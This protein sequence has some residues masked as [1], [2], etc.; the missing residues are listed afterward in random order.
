MTH[1][2][3]AAPVVVSCRSDISGNVYQLSDTPSP[4]TRIVLNATVSAQSHVTIDATGKLLFPG[5]PIKEVWCAT[6]GGDAVGITTAIDNQ[7]VDVTFSSQY[8]GT[9]LCRID[10]SEYTRRYQ[11][12]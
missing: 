11:V 9:V 3:G 1:S 2:P 10:Q 12:V 8:T 5:I 7:A 6:Q 4:N